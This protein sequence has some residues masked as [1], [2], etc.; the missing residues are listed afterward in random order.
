MGQLNILYRAFLEYRKLTQSNPELKGARRGYKNTDKDFDKFETIKLDVIID[1][2]WVNKIEK[3]LEFVT[4]AVLEERQFIET[5]GEVVPI[6]KVKRVSKASVSHLAKHSNLITKLPEDGKDIIPEKIYMVEKLSDY[7]VYENRFLYMLLC[8]LRDF[9]DLRLSKIE[10]A[11]SSYKSDF[12]MSKTVSNKTRKFLYET[13]FIEDRKDNEYPIINE[14]TKRT[15][16]RI[17]A[18]AHDVQALLKTDLMEQVSSAPM[19]KPPITKTNVLKMNNNFK[20]SVALYEFVAAY[21]VPGY[22]INEVK[23]EFTPFIEPFADEIVELIS[24]TSFLTYE[25]GNNLLEELKK[26]YEKEELLKKQEE[27]KKLIE[28]L[29]SLKRR[30]NESGKS[31]EE[32]MLLLEKRNRSLEKDSEDLVQA[33]KDIEGLNNEILQLN[34]EK[35]YLEDKIDSLYSDIQKLELLIED[36]K[37]KHL[38]ELEQKD[39]EHAQVMAKKEEQY[40]LEIDQLN[41]DFDNEKEVIISQYENSKEKMLLEFEEE[42][43]SIFNDHNAQVEKLTRKIELITDE[44]ERISTSVKVREKDLANKEKLFEEEKSKLIRQCNEAIKDNII[45]TNREIVV[46]KHETD[47]AI[48]EKNIA[49]AQLMAIKQL[50]GMLETEK[51]Y[52]TKEMIEQ[53]EMQKNAFNKFFKE[54]WKIAKKRIRKEILGS[55]NADISEPTFDFEKENQEKMKA[56]SD[57]NIDFDDNE[58]LINE[59]ELENIEEFE[60]EEELE[61]IEEFENEEGLEDI[62]EFENNEEL[63]DIEEFENEEE[64]EDIEEFENEEELENIE[65]FENEELED[66]EEFDNEEGLEDIEEFENNEE[67]EDIEEFENEEEL[68]DIEEFENEEELEN[69]EEFE[70]NKIIEHEELL[71]YIEEPMEETQD[72]SNSDDVSEEVSEEPEFVDFSS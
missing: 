65:E 62:E 3:G 63:E 52:S 38:E 44:N 58:L 15:I 46:A 57:T 18:C 7:T 51:D 49:L 61:D 71:E 1:E 25:Y 12:S 48:E 43:T 31:M 34:A 36:M 72:T 26:D 6:E 23:Q 50:T 14:K 28:Q 47:M 32:Y 5:T 22:T 39:I 27:E 37:I 33:R 69:I 20:N 24:L 16:E 68:E 42:R 70:S 11:I 59:E 29:N 21:N 17:K 35:G 2:E 64:L 66:I 30:V 41:E 19:I 55:K 54:Q 4:K 67:L 13:K 40:L 8:Y 56:N 10:E 9:I 45:T 53:L 60:D